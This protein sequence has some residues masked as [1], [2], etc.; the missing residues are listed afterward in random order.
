M[1]ISHLASE[2]VMEKGSLEV[3]VSDEELVEAI[4]VSC[5][6]EVTRPLDFF[7]ISIWLHRNIA[8]GSTLDRGMRVR[9]S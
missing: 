2:F 8:E 1:A 5:I 7:L 4:A 3:E 6:C 9:D